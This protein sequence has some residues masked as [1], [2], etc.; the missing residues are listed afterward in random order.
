MF[1]GCS[2]VFLFKSL[3]FCFS[4]T[5]GDH[6]SAGS[7]VMLIHG[8]HRISRPERGP[9]LP[10]LRLPRVCDLRGSSLALSAMKSCCSRTP[11][12]TTMAWSC[13]SAT[14]LGP[15]FI[16]PSPPPPPRRVTS[17]INRFSYH[18]LNYKFVLLFPG[19]LETESPRKFGFQIDNVLI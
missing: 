16:P 14:W 18:L 9:S 6:L 11:R 17:V 2:S 1:L 12:Q 13:H 5:P 10:G 19:V 4:L 15:L 8:F 3:V 7:R